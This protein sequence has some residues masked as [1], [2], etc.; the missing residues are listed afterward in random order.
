M[1]VP[2]CL[3]FR[4][5]RGLL[6]GLLAALASLTLMDGAWAGYKRE[7]LTIGL[8]NPR[9]LVI[10]PAGKILL[11]ES[12]RG[13]A[14][15]PSA[16]NCIPAPAG[17]PA[18]L[19]AGDSGAVAIYDPATN[20]FQRA[21]VGLPSLARAD[22]S[23]GT[24]L[25]DL[26]YG[27][28]GQLYGVFGLGGNPMALSDP[29][30]TLSPL[31]GKVVRLDLAPA[32]SAPITPVADIAGMELLLNP[33][34]AGLNSNP[35]SIAYLAGDL[36]INDAG[37]NSLLR[38]DSSNN[39]TLAHTYPGLQV[40]PP[41]FLGLPNPFPA[42]WVPTGLAVSG[43]TLYSGNLSGFPF[44]NGSASIL[45]N[46]GGGTVLAAGFSSITD[47]A[48][49][50]DGW[51]YLLQY[52]ENFF[53]PIT[54]SGSLWKLSPDGQ[55]RQQL[56]TGLLNP[57]GLAVDNEGRIYVANNADGTN[58]ELLRLTPAVPTPLPLLGLTAAFG[59]SRR[60]RKRLGQL[61]SQ[62]PHWQ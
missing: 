59:A 11:A 2:S 32:S 42:E 24:G 37:G 19:C 38:V 39:V 31:F 14:A 20:V 17:P 30:K 43:S 53:D 60:L 22:G 25:A 28:A 55:S 23:E 51:L 9:G 61:R 10:S 26:T 15:S 7:T 34:G 45:A 40:S 16:A 5:P 44:V 56:V 13:G 57:T 21:L 35:Y 18:T 1:Q 50:P 48:I 33:D 54:P 4:S 52:S 41:P 58:G 36:W 29:N 8:N 47:G 12:G 62:P 6:P 49:G 46:P 3:S 27:P